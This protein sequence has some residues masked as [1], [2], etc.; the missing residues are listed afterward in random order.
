MAIWGKPLPGG[1]SALGKGKSSVVLLCEV[2]G[3]EAAAKVRRVDAP[4]PDLRME[5]AMLRAANSV[6][7]GPRILGWGR[8]VIVMELVEG[9]PLE[10]LLR[11]RGLRGAADAAASA[12]DGARALDA[13]GID[14]GE[15]HRPG[16]HV[17][18][19]GREAVILD[20]G[21]ASASRRPSNVTS[22]ASAIARAA[23]SIR[24]PEL[25]RALRS[26]KESLAR[27]ES[28][29]AEYREVLRALG[30]GRAARQISL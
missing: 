21:S 23:G 20:F 14:H 26:Y 17:T 15:L 2:G 4:V 19:R 12:L 7:V 25:R 18:V 8:T 13:A 9:V 30:L 27:G 10:E 24:D 29:E 16:H 22:L 3:V 1:L 6:G 5:A 28:G 11:A